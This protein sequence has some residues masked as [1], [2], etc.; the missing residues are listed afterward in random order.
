MTL[1]RAGENDDALDAFRRV[2][3]LQPAEPRGHFNL[4][5]QLERMG[6]RDEALPVYRHFLS[7]AP[8]DAFAGERSRAEQALRNQ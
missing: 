1:A 4:A 2:V 6:Q 5:V 7:I 3:R 8:E